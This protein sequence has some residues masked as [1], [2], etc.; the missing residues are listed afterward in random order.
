MDFSECTTWIW[1]KRDCNCSKRRCRQSQRTPL[2]KR[3]WQFLKEWSLMV[4]RCS[5]GPERSL[6]VGK[7]HDFLQLLWENPIGFCALWMAVLFSPLFSVSLK[8]LIVSFQCQRFEPLHVFLW[9]RDPLPLWN[10]PHGIHRGLH[11]DYM[12]FFTFYDGLS[13]GSSIPSSRNA[14]C[15]TFVPILWSLLP[16]LSNG[17]FPNWW[18]RLRSNG[19]WVTIGECQFDILGMPFANTPSLKKIGENLHIGFAPSVTASGMSS[20]SLEV[21]DGRILH[22]ILL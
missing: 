9:N 6:T 17:P 7:L 15:I 21:E 13:P 20:W 18:V 16:S 10:V 4:E 12:T 3:R 5:R 19:L 2:A 14:P 22:F 1:E 8:G 11:R